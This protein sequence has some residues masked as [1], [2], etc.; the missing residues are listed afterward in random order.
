MIRTC[1]SCGQKNRIPAKHLHEVGYCGACKAPLPP[2]NAPLEVDQA[3]FDQIV[4]E[5]QVPVLV[6][7]WAE[8]CGP[9]RMAGPTRRP[10]GFAASR[11]GGSSADEKLARAGSQGRLARHLQTP[12]DQTRALEPKDR[13][14]GQTK[15][16]VRSGRRSAGPAAE[17]RIASPLIW[18]PASNQIRNQRR[19]LGL[20]LDQR[21]LNRRVIPG[22]R[23]VSKHR[24][25]ERRGH[26]SIA[27][28]PE[29]M[30]ERAVRSC[31]QMERLL[32][33]RRKG[34]ASDSA[35]DDG[36]PRRNT[37]QKPDGAMRS[38]GA[39]LQIEVEHR[40]E[41][42]RSSATSNLDLPLKKQV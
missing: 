27:G 26:R 19:L 3:T 18:I 12:P 23:T 39:T 10:C 38:H 42:Y 32:Y 29:T 24:G 28:L 9:C 17:P 33:D 41:S 22:D 5:A 13:R 11:T 36:D 6:D 14:Q 34:R 30:T 7:F 40:D 15:R 20:Q 16:D 4:Q 21:G 25:P 1:P 37:Q 8:W 31:W 35:W 2:T